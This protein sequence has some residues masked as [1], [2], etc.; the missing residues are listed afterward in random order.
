MVVTA[1]SFFRALL[2]LIMDRFPE[3]LNIRDHMLAPS[4]SY[5]SRSSHSLWCMSSTFFILSQ[6]IS[7]WLQQ[8][9]F[10]MKHDSRLLYLSLWL[11]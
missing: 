7:A 4:L 3:L 9:S 5:A 8:P 11:L 2:L 10:M 6:I 1:L